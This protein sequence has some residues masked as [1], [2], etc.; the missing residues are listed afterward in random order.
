MQYKTVHN[1][2]YT[3]HRNVPW[4]TLV[5]SGRRPQQDQA[6]PIINKPALPAR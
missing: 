1:T 5:D 4:W 3:V 2:P 6:P